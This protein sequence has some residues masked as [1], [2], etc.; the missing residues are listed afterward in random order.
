[1]FISVLVGTEAG[2]G[3]WVG[4]KEHLCVAPWYNSIPSIP[5]QQSGTASPRGELPP[6][7]FSLSTRKQEEAW[8]PQQK[9][10]EALE[11]ALS[12]ACDHTSPQTGASPKS[13]PLTPLRP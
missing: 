2:C 1:M 10:K 5:A 7:A 4:S 13:C 12:A 9:L 6:A 11:A 3:L 8:L